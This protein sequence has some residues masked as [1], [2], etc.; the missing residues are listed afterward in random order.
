MI[1]DY[2]DDLVESIKVEAPYQDFIAAKQKVTEDPQ[3]NKELNTMQRLLDEK[4][5]LSKYQSY[6]SLD[7]INEKI[8]AQKQVLQSFPA[9]IDYQNALYTLNKQLEELSQ[10]TFGGISEELIIGRI[11]KIYARHS[12][13]V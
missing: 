6:I 5:D 10:I 12:R 4:E 8:K 9:M 1:Y 3:L 11:G 2:I 13:S 7:E